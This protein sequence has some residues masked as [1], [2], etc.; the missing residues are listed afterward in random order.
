MLQVTDWDPSHLGQ[1]LIKHVDQSREFYELKLHD[2]RGWCR[3]NCVTVGIKEFCQYF[4]KCKK[5]HDQ[6]VF[7]FPY[8]LNE[9]NFDP[10]IW[11]TV[12]RPEQMVVDL[13]SKEEKEL[14]RQN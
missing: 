12:S 7:M 8:H 10:T 5:Q 11:R 2:H 1:L 4:S 9:A 13:R 3:F 6:K 14:I